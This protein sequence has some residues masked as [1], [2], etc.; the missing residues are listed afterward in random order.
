MAHQLGVGAG[1]NDA[2]LLH[3]HDALRLLYGRQA[4]RND[5]RRAATHQR[6]Q[7]ILDRALA[8]RI[9][10]RG[11]FV[12]QQDGRVAQDGAGD[13]D[14]LALAARQA[15]AALAQEGAVA[16]GQR[17][18]EGG[19]VGGDRGGPDLG[20]GRLGPAVADILHR[21]GREDHRILRDD[22]DAGAQRLRLA[23]L[24]IDPIHPD[25]ALLRVVEAQQQLEYRRLAGAAGSDQGDRFAR[26][27]LQAEIRQRRRFGTSGIAEF[28][29]IELD[30]ALGR[31]AA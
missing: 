25:R 10:C 4:V 16:V 7:R 11:R 5:Q 22:G 24:E 19:G 29:S 20:I 27:H 13:G 12:E 30:G 15:D 2:T 28:D 26:L 23:G 31:A 9:Q 3:H 8:L 18:D 17:L 14:A 21:R 6:L 1:G